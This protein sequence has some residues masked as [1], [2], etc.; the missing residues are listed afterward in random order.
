MT[1]ADP[2]PLSEQQHLV[3]DGVS[4]GY[5]ERTLE[6]IGDRPL[7]VTFHR[8]TIEI[9]PPLSEHEFA[10]S[11]IGVLIEVMA[12]ELDVPMQSFGSTT[13]RRRD[14]QAGLEPDQC[15]YLKNESKVRGM[16]RFEPK[17]HP[18]PDLA[19]EIDITSRSIAREPVYADLGVP[20][21]WRYNGRRLTVLVLNSSRKYVAAETSAGFPFLPIRPFE[22]FIHRMERE[23]RTT[24]VREFRDWVKTLPSR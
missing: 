19:V 15:Y 20:E 2:I 12:M 9:M 18:P 11:T 6:E 13:F 7:R 3:L 14:K 8:G 10:K 16:K 4:W 1:L 22:A 23:A 17:R 24:V 5:Y 21:L